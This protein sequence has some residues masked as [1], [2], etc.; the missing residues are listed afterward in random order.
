VEPIRQA[1]VPTRV[2]LFEMNREQAQSER[3]RMADE[4]PEATWLV[5][6]QEPGDWAIVKVSLASGDDSMRI[7]STE[8]RPAPPYPEDPRSHVGRNNPYGGI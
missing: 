3:D 2:S 6:E 5:A 8:E 1:G 4:H 7:E